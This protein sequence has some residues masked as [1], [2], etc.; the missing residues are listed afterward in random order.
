MQI[1]GYIVNGADWLTQL[2]LYNV[3][4]REFGYN[5]TV[6][7]NLDEEIYEDIEVDVQKRVNEFQVN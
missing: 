3:C 2:K 4:H 1:G 6:C 5:D 7:L